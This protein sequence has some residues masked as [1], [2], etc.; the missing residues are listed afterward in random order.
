MNGSDNVWGAENQQR[1]LE[2]RLCWLGG[3]IDGE[4]MITAI[5]R[6]EHKRRQAGFIPRISIANTDMVMID[7]VVA[8]LTQLELVH[9]LQSWTDRGHEHWKR[10]YEVII[11]G[12]LRCSEALPIMIPYLVVKRSKAERLL[13]FCESRRSHPTRTPY[14]EE[15]IQLALSLRERI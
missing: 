5:K 3:I 2:S 1:S 15:E 11:N 10:K 7:E 14:S 6:S 13:R 9:Y 8:I 12:I 4:G